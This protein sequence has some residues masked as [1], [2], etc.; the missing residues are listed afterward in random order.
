MQSLINLPRAVF[1]LY[2]KLTSRA[3][4]GIVTL[5][6]LSEAITLTLL[7]AALGS[8]QVGP[9]M[10]TIPPARVQLHPTGLHPS[11]WHGVTAEPESE[12]GVYALA[13]PPQP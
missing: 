4:S 9:G 1:G 3:F 12:G 2:A 10:Q 6:G 13:G 7:G 11:A 8:V 5:I